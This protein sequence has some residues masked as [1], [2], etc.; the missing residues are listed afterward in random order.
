[1]FAG[2]CISNCL[3]VLFRAPTQDS[4]Q[5]VT[6]LALTEWL[7]SQNSQGNRLCKFS[8]KMNVLGRKEQ[9]AGW[10]RETSLWRDLGSGDTHQGCTSWNVWACFLCICCSL[11]AF[12]LEWCIGGCW[13]NT[14]HPEDVAYWGC[15][16]Q[17]ILLRGWI[18][19]HLNKVLKT[20]THS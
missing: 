6:F 5:N 9:E 20:Q 4:S 17:N 19:F 1:M 3:W 16:G 13:Q 12:W 15:P 8:L 2:R 14:L 7:F 11:N 10:D 18:P